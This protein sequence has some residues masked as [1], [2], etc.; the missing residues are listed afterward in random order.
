MINKELEN[1]ASDAK[2]DQEY[3]TVM[4]EAKALFDQKK[5][6]EARAKYVQA[7]SIKSAEQAPKDKVI[8]IDKILADK[9][10]T[11]K[12]EAD[13]QKLISEGNSLKDIKDYTAAIDRYNKALLLKPADPVATQ[14]IAE[15]N[16]LIADQKKEAELQKQFDDYMAKA[17]TSF[18]ANEL[19]KSI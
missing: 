15:I 10:K 19:S 1:Q 6:I 5:Y 18:N 16:K 13:Y 14:K 9:E 8:E 12:L 7:T 2:K 17:S 3:N 4:A 11:E